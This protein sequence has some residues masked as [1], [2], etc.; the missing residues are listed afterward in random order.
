[1]LT[2]EQVTNVMKDAWLEIQLDHAFMGYD[3]DGTPLYQTSLFT[4][5]SNKLKE[6]GYED[7]NMIEVYDINSVIYKDGPCVSLKCRG[8]E[9]E[10][11]K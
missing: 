6:R 11:E 5:K 10:E 4:I 7:L 3:D 2:L 1:M 8:I 9:V